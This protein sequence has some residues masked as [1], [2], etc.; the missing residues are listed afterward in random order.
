MPAL[1][2]M[3]AIVRYGPALEKGIAGIL[4]GNPQHFACPG[5]VFRLLASWWLRYL[6]Q[7]SEEADLH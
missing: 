7:R 1:R 4:Y 3:P 2:F 6:V 5:D